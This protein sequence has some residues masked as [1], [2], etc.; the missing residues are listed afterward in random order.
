MATGELDAA[1]ADALTHALASGLRGTRAPT[2]EVLQ[3]RVEL[4]LLRAGHL[5]T[6]RAYVVYREQHAKLRRDRATAS[7]RG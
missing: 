6:A 2:V 1:Q 5:A 7:R 3:D 4:T